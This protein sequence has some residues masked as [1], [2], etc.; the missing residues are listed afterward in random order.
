MDAALVVKADPA[1]QREFEIEPC[2]PGAS[3]DQLRLDRRDRALCHG[4]VERS[5]GAS[6]AGGDSGV[7]E[8]L[9]VLPGR[10]LGA[11]VVGV[12]DEWLARPFAAGDRHREGVVDERSRMRARFGVKPICRELEVSDRAYRQRRGGLPSRRAQSDAASLVEIRT[13]H[14]RGGS[15]AGGSRRRDGR[16]VRVV[17]LLAAAAKGQL[18]CRALHRR[19]A[20]ARG[21][22]R[23]RRRPSR[24]DAPHDDPTPTA[25]RRHRSRREALPGVAARRAVGVRLHLH[26]H[27]REARSRGRPSPPRRRSRFSRRSST[28]S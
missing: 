27:P 19:A 11:A 18:R 3:L 10:V 15:S 14:A 12:R 7:F 22:S 26:P 23:R 4:V 13:F 24:S 2:R 6:A 1:E 28:S 17:A 20:D 5:A 8:A 25:G 16:V 9:G 21:R